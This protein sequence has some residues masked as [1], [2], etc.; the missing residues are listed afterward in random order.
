MKDQEQKKKQA[1]GF[2]LIECVIAIVVVTVGLLGVAALAAVAIQS[3]T[4]AFNSSSAAALA[5]SKMEELKAGALNNGGSLTSNTNGYSDSPNAYFYRRWQ[6]AN[7]PAGTKEISVV[8][9]PKG[10]ATS[11]RTTKIKTLV[12]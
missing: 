1:A 2:S 12:R 9:V 10:S 8:V 11:A 4:F 5:A 7:G 3:E 6:I